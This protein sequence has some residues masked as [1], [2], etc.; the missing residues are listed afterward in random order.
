MKSERDGGGGVERRKRGRVGA[1][2]QAALRGAEHFA[3]EY[4]CCGPFSSFPKQCQPDYLRVE[5]DQ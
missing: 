3:H 4:I 5:R 2:V 1:F